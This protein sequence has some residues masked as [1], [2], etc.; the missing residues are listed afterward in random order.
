MT[1]ITNFFIFVHGNTSNKFNCILSFC[2]NPILRAELNRASSLLGFKI[3]PY[4]PTY[5]NSPPISSF[6]NLSTIPII[7][8]PHN[9]FSLAKHLLVYGKHKHNHSYQYNYYKRYKNSNKEEKNDLE[10]R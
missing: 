5:N 9:L 10:N 1:I 2:R 8:P 6:Q 7:L 4:S 3:E